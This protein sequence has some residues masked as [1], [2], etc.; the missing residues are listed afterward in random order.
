L[1]IS[2]KEFN[3]GKTLL[4]GQCYNWKKLKKHKYKGILR[5]YLVVIERIDPETISFYS[6]PDMT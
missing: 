4:N 6:A 5:S 3:L 1:K 2:D